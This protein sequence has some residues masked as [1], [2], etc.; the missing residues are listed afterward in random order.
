MKRILFLFVSVLVVTTGFAQKG[1]VAAASAFIDNGDLDAAQERIMEAM[2]HEKTKG[3]PRTYITAANLATKQ[4]ENGGGDQKIIEAADY[5]FKASEYDQKGNEKGK[6]IGKAEKEIKV[7]IT[8]FMPKL[9]NAG[10]EAFNKENYEVALNIFERVIGLNKLPAF[11]EDELPAD[12]VFIYYSG[13]AA[14]RS[15][16]WEKAKTYFNQAIDLGYEKGNTVL[17][18]HEVYAESGDSSKMAENLKRGFETYPDDDRILTTLINYYL[19]TEQNQEALNYLNSAIE[20]DP[21]N[22]IYYNARGVLYDLSE[23]FDKAEIEY[24][25][26]IELNPD[27]F[28]AILNLGVVY[29]NRGAEEMNKANDFKKMADYEAGRKKAEAIFKQS[30]PYLERAHEIKPDNIMVLE[31]LKNLYYRFDMDAE[32]DA[33][34]SKIKELKGM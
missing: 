31:T 14:T 23:E 15:Q 28:D 26:A 29:Y 8:F 33:T 13:L 1:K 12:S 11:A 9:Q 2:N 4:F 6:G 25:K 16:N 24:K 22:Y 17:M 3:W 21:E 20:K 7:A 19:K 34:D 27:F 30:L 18:L 10:V 5:F 32:Y